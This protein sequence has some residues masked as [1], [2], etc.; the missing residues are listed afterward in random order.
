MTNPP[1]D[2]DFTA[3]SAPERLLLAQ[4]LLDSVLAE[5]MPL[6]VQQLDEVT[7]R[8]AAIDA[9]EM[10]CEPWETVRARLLHPE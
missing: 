5:A 1:D 9:G 8:A 3:L 6:T 10:T 7:R 2:F 4:Q